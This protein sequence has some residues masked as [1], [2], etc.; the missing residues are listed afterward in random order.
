G[1]PD[2][3][4]EFFGQ[5]AQET[6]EHA[7]RA[8]LLP[9]LAQ[10]RVD[11]QEPGEE[12]AAAAAAR[13][14][15]VLGAGARPQSL[16]LILQRARCITQ[17]GALCR[18]RVAALGMRRRL[19]HASPLPV[20]RGAGRRGPEA[21][22]QR[23]VL[24]PRPAGLQSDQRARQD[25]VAFLVAH[26][27]YQLVARLEQRHRVPGYERQLQAQ[28]V[29]AVALLDVVAAPREEHLARIGVA[30]QRGR[31]LAEPVQPDDLV[32][33]QRRVAD[34]NRREALLDGLPVAGL[35]LLP[36]VE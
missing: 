18:Q 29:L 10:L 14:T 28:H 1:R 24:E 25:H 31:H 21:N 6:R 34:G 32:A 22:A 20:A 8:V 30:V 7:A 27:H 19:G 33:E 11:V 9:P 2:V 3:L 35:R 23:A 26:V 17:A 12:A 4:Q 36:G 13:S 15:L 5:V 16:T